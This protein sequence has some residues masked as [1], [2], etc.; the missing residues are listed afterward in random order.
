MASRSIA[1]CAL[2]GL[3]AGVFGQAAPPE[4]ERAASADESD[5]TIVVINLRFAD[6]GEIA[7]V[8]RELLP[9][10]VRVVSYYPTN[11]VLIA[12]DPAVIGELQQPGAQEAEP[13]KDIPDGRR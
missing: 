11:S 6:A 5:W 8:L 2:L 3:A 7:R 1:T 13:P 9:P 10:T 12:G 4:S